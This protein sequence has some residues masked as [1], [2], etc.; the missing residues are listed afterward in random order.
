MMKV[1]D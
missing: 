1:V